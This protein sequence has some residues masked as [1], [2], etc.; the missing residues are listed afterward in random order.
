[1]A[2][3]RFTELGGPNA[4]NVHFVQTYSFYGKLTPLGEQ[5][6][7]ELKAEYP[8][9]KQPGDITPAVGVANAYDGTRLTA[10]A[11]AKAGST[12]GDAIRKGYYAI[13][14]HPGL[15]E[16]YAHPFSP[17]QHDALTEN[18]YVWR[19]SSTTALCPSA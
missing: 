19:S 11:I 1:M 2:G 5:V 14:S 10:L 3:G 4:S 9:I 6:V 12:D 18:D 7:K 17:A 13:D 8:D 15:I 16:T